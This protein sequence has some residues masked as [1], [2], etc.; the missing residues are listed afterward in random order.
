MWMQV[1]SCNPAIRDQVKT[2]LKESLAHWQETGLELKS[3]VSK[4]LIKQLFLALD[5]N[6]PEEIVPAYSQPLVFDD[7]VDA[8]S[9]SKTMSTVF[10]AYQRG[11]QK[12]DQL[13]KS[14]RE[15]PNK[16]ARK[17]NLRK[18]T[19]NYDFK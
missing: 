5:G 18:D 3:D 11:A 17:P 2:E 14:F 13:E 4:D 19:Q 15:D 10:G 9:L 6:Q 8:A 12:T 16:K 1:S 7:T